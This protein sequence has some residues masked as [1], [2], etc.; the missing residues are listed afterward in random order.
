MERSR[1][2]SKKCFSVSFSLPLFFF[3]LKPKSPNLKS[4]ANCVVK[5]NP[6]LLSDLSPKQPVH[7]WLQNTV[8][9]TAFSKCIF[10]QLSEKKKLKKIKKRVKVMH[11]PNYNINCKKENA[12]LV[13][14]ND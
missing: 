3:F 7:Y 14:N 9:C 5:V 13:Q 10:K 6:V 12:E 11:N 4:T 2:A 8:F 1:Q